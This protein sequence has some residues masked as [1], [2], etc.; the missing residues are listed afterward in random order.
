MDHKL[1]I[2]IVPATSQNPIQESAALLEPFQRVPLDS[3]PP[4]FD[5]KFR[6]KRVGGWFD[7]MLRNQVVELRWSTF[8]RMLFDGAPTSAQYP[9]PGYGPETAAEIERRIEVANTMN[10]DDVSPLAPIS[11]IVTPAGQWLT[12]ANPDYLDE[13]QACDP[14]ARREQDESWASMKRAIFEEHRGATAV[15]WDLSRHFLGLPLQPTGERR[16]LF[17]SGIR[18]RSQQSSTGTQAWRTRILAAQQKRQ[19]QGEAES[20]S[21][22]ATRE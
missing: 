9:V 2:V 8:L 3:V 14:N 12:T 21:T 20:L 16:S 11:I 1:A 17:R 15:A 5:Q 10:L 18:R 6:F 22:S 13:S 7:G 4:N 19:L